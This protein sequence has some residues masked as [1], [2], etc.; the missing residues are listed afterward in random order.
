MAD[1][2]DLNDKP[3]VV[4]ALTY[5]SRGWPV[6]PVAWVIEITGICACRQGPSCTH[7]AKHPLVPGGTASATTDLAQV[8]SWWAHWPL[9]GIGLV[10][11]SRSGLAVLDIDLGH[12]GSGTL[13]ALGSQGII[14]PPTLCADT[15]GGGQHYFFA[16]GGGMRV[17]N[18]SSRLPGL[19]NTPGI[20][21]RGEG[22]YVVAAP[23]LHRS[24]RRYAWRGTGDGLAPLPPW[25]TKPASRRETGHPV[26][27]VKPG[28]SNRYAAE[29]LRREVAAV[30]A[31][32]EGQRSDQLNRS[33]FALGTLVGAG[34]LT[35]SDV[36]TDL[37][38]T[39]THIGLT[40]TEATRTIRSGLRAGI[41]RPRRVP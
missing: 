33:A 3:P 11:G 34:A 10:T 39:A 18:T 25:M 15:G 38:R 28:T 30:A 31:A 27:V 7:P 36:V 19:G 9:A 41:A 8:R 23:S 29:V 13:N 26:P 32:P 17:P 40:P 1:L 5:A 21:I 4:A 12:D 22:G 2:D 6:F 20:D 24:G 14:V 16:I 37:L 35:E